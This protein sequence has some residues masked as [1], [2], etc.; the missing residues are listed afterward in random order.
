MAISKRF[1]VLLRDSSGDPVIGESPVFDWHTLSD[2]SAPQAINVAMVEMLGGVGGAYVGTISPVVRGEDYLA[3][4]HGVADLGDTHISFS[5]SEVVALVEE[6]QEVWTG[7]GLNPSAPITF[8]SQG[9][10]VQ[11]LAN[12]TPIDLAISILGSAVTITR[13]P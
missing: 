11:A 12:V 3:V 4:I 9:G 6:L 13:Q 8:D 10:F 2:P 5:G 7:L 1:T